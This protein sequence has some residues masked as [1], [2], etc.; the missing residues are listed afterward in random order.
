MISESPKPFHAGPSPSEEDELDLSQLFAVLWAGRLK[1]AS[2]VC[3][4]L[5]LGILYLLS[6]KPVFIGNG[7][8]QVE[9]SG[10]SSMANAFGDLSSLFGTPLE[11]QAEI[12]I[13]Q[14]R[15]ILTKVTETLKLEIDARPKY[16]PLL[17]RFVAARHDSQDGLASPFLGLSGYAWG[18]EEIE[19]STFSVPANFLG[20]TFALVA[21][22]DD[23]FDLY[24]D[25]HQLV[26]NGQVGR[27]EST[28]IKGG[29]LQ[30]FVRVLTARP[31]TQF[32]LSRRP[33]AEVIA[34][35]NDN[36]KVVEQGK[37]SGVIKLILEGPSPTYVTDV[38]RQ[39]QDAYVRQNVER[40]SAEAQ[41]SLEFLQKQLP[42]IRARVDA[43]QAR[44]NAYQLKQGS[45]DVTKE[46]ELILQQSIDLETKR[47]DLQQQRQQAIQRFT[48]QHP[49]VQA[50]DSQIKSI[51]SEQNDVKKRAEILPETQQEVLS[52]MRDLEVN[53]QIYTTLLNSTQ[54]LQ[55]AKAGTVGNVRVIDYPLM[56]TEAAKPK[57]FFVIFA[58]IVL[59]GVAGLAYVLVQRALFK[60][61]DHPDEVEKTFGIATYAAI[62]YTI[63]QR[64]LAA[65]TK[66][67]ESGTHILASIEPDNP[68]IEALRSL[69]T[70]LQ[71]AL[72]ESNNNIVVFTGPTPG[73]GKSFVS[74]NLA[75]VLATSGKKV[76]VVDADLRRGYLHK[77]MGETAAPGLSDYVVGNADLKS[78][79]RKT[80]VEGLTMVP[81]GTVPPNP[82][83]LLLHERFSQLLGHLSKTHDLVIVDTPPV[84]PV[85]DASVIGRLAGC[86][87]VVLKEGAHPM[88]MI[89]ETL[90]R[91]RQAGVTVRGTIFNQVGRSG[92]GYGYYYSAYGY[93]Y[94][95]KYKSEA[96]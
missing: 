41:Q 25:E 75:A 49:V 8:V 61:V 42:E 53:T 80:A 17:G 31:S 5:V 30:V 66:R 19:V 23:K 54:E 37:Q 70:S 1:I 79:I 21:T 9:E 43:A 16:L 64:R 12:Q 48:S 6:T 81:N 13:L 85:T 59:G 4:A 18:G 52:L 32:K 74:V 51:E 89:D 22:G 73:L 33:F 34:V 28:N 58:A 29:E 40:R 11:T 86:V 14:S 57:P 3:A 94:Q 69:R 78:I 83:E 7:L 56:P 27:L 68:S 62:P 44:L 60:G 47:L 76:A 96:R 71:F 39:M 2:A 20:K 90:R 84:L 35:L 82:S 77:Y 55:V 50:L 65:A 95:S 72:L 45:I 46:T 88:R 67:K 36:L 87:F 10:K 63:A 24:D 15:M 26:L 91:L 38:I 92:G 93:S